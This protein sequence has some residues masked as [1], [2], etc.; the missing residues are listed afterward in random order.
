MKK[1]KSEKSKERAKKKGRR[2]V[3]EINSCSSPPLRKDLRLRGSPN[4]PR[5]F[6]V[7]LLRDDGGSEEGFFSFLVLP[8]G[9]GRVQFGLMSPI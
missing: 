1:R 9:E 7:S 2:R 3:K 5:L 8:F 4:Q 6:F